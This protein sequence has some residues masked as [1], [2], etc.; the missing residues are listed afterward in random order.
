MRLTLLVAGLVACL[1]VSALAQEVTCY[2]GTKLR[3]GQSAACGRHGG[4]LQPGQE[5][6]LPP[7]TGRRTNSAPDTAT[8]MADTQTRPRSTRGA[9]QSQTAPGGGPGEV[10]VN[11]SSKVYHCPSDRYYGKTKRGSYMTEAAAKAAGAHPS[12]GK[13]CS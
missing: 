11:A 12:G 5:G 13:A 3:A 1:S 10:W 6:A 8:P 7:D 4:V 2:D 9:P